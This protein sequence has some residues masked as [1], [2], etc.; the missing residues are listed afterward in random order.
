MEERWDLDK[1]AWGALADEQAELRDSSSIT[2]LWECMPDG[3]HKK[4]TSGP[5]ESL[6][7]TEAKAGQNPHILISYLCSPVPGTGYGVNE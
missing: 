4:N 1:Q 2:G 3:Q 7:V 5:P 6:P